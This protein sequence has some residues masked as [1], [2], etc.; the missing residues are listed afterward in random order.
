MWIRASGQ[1]LAQYFRGPTVCVRR[2]LKGG[3]I[4]KDWYPENI[5]AN[6][7]CIWIRIWHLLKYMNNG[8]VVGIIP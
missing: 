3:N 6:C 4:Q 8:Y 2:A 7:I 5:G 1:Y